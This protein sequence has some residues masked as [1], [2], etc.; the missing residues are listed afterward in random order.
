MN[1]SIGSNIDDHQLEEEKKEK[2]KACSDNALMNLVSQRK[3]KLLI[4]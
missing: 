2:I 3:S 4:D 1:Q